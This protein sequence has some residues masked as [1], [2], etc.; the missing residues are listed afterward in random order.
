[1]LDEQTSISKKKE[2]ES[3]FKKAVSGPHGGG[4]PEY[5]YSK[6]CYINIKIK[7]PNFEM[8]KV[9]VTPSSSCAKY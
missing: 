2:D 5:K 7:V 3:S 8:G 9:G 4:H 6:T 1:M